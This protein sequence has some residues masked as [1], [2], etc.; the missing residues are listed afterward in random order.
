[1]RL[2]GVPLQ[3]RGVLLEPDAVQDGA[4]PVSAPAVH[5]PAV[6]DWVIDYTDEGAIW[7]VT[8]VAWYRYH[9][10]HTLLLLAK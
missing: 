7:L 3:A 8:D 2:A 1:M 10:Q 6:R 5:L 4:S 9:H